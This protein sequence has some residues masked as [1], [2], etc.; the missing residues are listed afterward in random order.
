MKNEAVIGGITVAGQPTEDELRAMG[1]GRFARVI[2]I[3]RDDEPG[4]VSGAVLAEGGPAYT[5][6]P[7]TI[8]TVTAAEIRRIRDAIDATPGPVLVH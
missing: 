5:A 3:R 1:G 4:N 6:V 7:W 2:D 8:D